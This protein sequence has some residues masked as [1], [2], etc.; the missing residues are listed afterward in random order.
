MRDSIRHGAIHVRTRVRSPGQN[1]VREHAFGSL[2]YERLY[3]EE[4][5]HHLALVAA[6]ADY[7]LDFNKI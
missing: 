5:G 4:I 6:A 1:G 3:L 2:K 7:R